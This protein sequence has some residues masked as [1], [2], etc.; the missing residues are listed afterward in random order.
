[1]SLT[2]RVWT[3]LMVKFCIEPGESSREFMAAMQGPTGS[4]L[5]GATWMVAASHEPLRKR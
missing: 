5:T 3:N 1:M 2:G 4:F